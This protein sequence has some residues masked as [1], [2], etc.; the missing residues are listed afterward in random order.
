MEMQTQVAK[1]DRFDLGFGLI[2]THKADGKR[3]LGAYNDTRVLVPAGEGIVDVR[4]LTDAE[5][6]GMDELEK[7]FAEHG[8]DE[9]KRPTKVVRF[10]RGALLTSD[11]VK[12]YQ[13]GLA[14]YATDAAAE[15]KPEAERNIPLEFAQ[16]LFDGVESEPGTVDPAH[17]VALSMAFLKEAMKRNPAETI[18]DML[19]FLESKLRHGGQVDIGVAD[20]DAMQNGPQVLMHVA[21]FNGMVATMDRLAIDVYERYIVFFAPGNDPVPQAMDDGS[22]ARFM[23]ASGGDFDPVAG[24]VF[25]DAIEVETSDKN[26]AGD[27]GFAIGKLPVAIGAGT[28]MRIC[29]AWM[30]KAIFAGTKQ[31]GI[32]RFPFE[33]RERGDNKVFDITDEQVGDTVTF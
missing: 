13:H 3:T 10:A 8:E 33:E 15:A 24:L 5:R 18:K 11:G 32:A 19:G 31:D 21:K 28:T 7:V 1:L 22:K 17:G 29:K 6:E 27:S 30:P 4:D 9:F 14:V 23:E 2:P 25:H 16:A 12:S 20:D 26:L